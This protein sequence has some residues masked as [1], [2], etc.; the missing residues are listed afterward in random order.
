MCN[1]NAQ[2]DELLALSSIYDEEKFSVDKKRK[3][4]SFVV[5]VELSQ[6]FTIIVTANKAGMNMV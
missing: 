3:S 4:G 2:T 5:N 6:P 1:Q